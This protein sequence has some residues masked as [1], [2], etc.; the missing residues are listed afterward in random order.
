MPPP[1]P[2]PPPPNVSSSLTFLLA[3]IHFSNQKKRY[4]CGL[5]CQFCVRRFRGF[6]RTV[7]TVARYSLRAR[8]NAVIIFRASDV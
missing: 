2:P 1:P 7:D 5:L 6:Q 8:D 4:D 3:P